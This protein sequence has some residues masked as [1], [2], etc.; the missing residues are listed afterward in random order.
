MR[1]YIAAL[2]II[3]LFTGM[4]SAWAP[5]DIEWAN[6]VSGTLHKGGTLTN[7]QYMVKVVEFSAAVPGVKDINGDIVPET[8]VDPSV[9]LELY[10]NGTLIKQFILNRG[11]EPFI[12]S[13]YEVK[14]SVTDFT[15]GNAKEWVY[16]YYNPSATI[17]IQTRGKPKIDVTVTTDKSTYTS[18]EDSIITAT[19][20]VTNS[21]SARA[22]NVDVILDTGGLKLRGGSS[23]QLH[24]NYNIMEEG[25]SQSFSVVL[26]VPELIDQKSYV[27]SANATANDAKDLQYKA[28][29]GSVTIP[30]SPKQNY[31]TISKAVSKDRIYLQDTILVR[32]TVANSGM[33][34]AYNINVTD[35]MSDY[36]EL[37]SNTSFHWDLPF[38]KA[39]EWREMTYSIKPL[40]TNINGFKIPSASA[41]FTV[42]NK[43]YSTSSKPITVIINGPQIILNKT[44]N[45]AFVNLS[46]NVTVMVRINNVGDIATKVRVNDSLP[47]DVSLVSGLMSLNSTLLDLNSPKT[48]NYTIRMNA[49][50][51]F[52]L[53]A[54]V[55]NFTDFEYRGLTRAS[56]ISG[57]PVVTVIN[58]SKTTPVPTG[59]AAGNPLQTQAQGG[60]VTASQA[61]KPEP[62][63]IT[64]GF[65]IGFAIIILVIIGVIKRRCRS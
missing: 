45:K 41:R 63:P 27:L 5:G 48:F 12:D 65:G 28:L 40:E 4:A 59:N 57:R 1:Y 29:T 54:A 22:E 9:F 35:S 8:D 62:T 60:P 20:K 37:K 7:G 33:F 32:L 49:E 14:V 6:D 10:N 53:P 19:V 36:F 42:N 50:G 46:E 16:E 39:G 15:K 61:D 21:G 64:P 47:D 34:D 26:L 55:A 30:V 2:F 13:D 3:V 23:S 25:T 11:S 31:F 58:K 24:Q 52:V 43:P 38:L 51:R 56:N 18:Y 17:L 44:V